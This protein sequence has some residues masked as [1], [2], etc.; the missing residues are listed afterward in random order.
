MRFNHLFCLLKKRLFL[1]G[2]HYPHIARVKTEGRSGTRKYNFLWRNFVTHFQQGLCT[3]TEMHKLGA[4]LFYKEYACKYF[5]K[6]VCGWGIHN[7]YKE[8]YYA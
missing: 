6:W 4:Y 3:N 2:L 8:A 1:L 7:T 5:K